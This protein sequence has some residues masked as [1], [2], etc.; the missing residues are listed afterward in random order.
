MGAIST[1]SNCRAARLFCVTLAA[2]VA[3]C[4]SSPRPTAELT[5]AHTLIDQAEQS[6]A[7]QYA[8]ADLKS[9]RDKTGAAEAAADK[10]DTV[11]AQRL[12]TE[13]A[14]DAQLATA[15]AED[16]KAQRSA[17]ELNDSLD[18]LRSESAR[19][20]GAAAP[21]APADSA[22]PKQPE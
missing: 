22:A 7:Q 6:G 8:P 17:R 11:A 5:R 3:G 15:R 19:K 18:T 16:A 9:A 2:L 14:L 10:R 13:A 4:A 1:T 21:P 12:A 20:A